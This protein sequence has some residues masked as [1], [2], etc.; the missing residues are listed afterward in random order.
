MF[1]KLHDILGPKLREFFPRRSR[2]RSQNGETTTKPR[3]SAAL[4]FF[5]GGSVLDIMLNHGM[6]K[7]AVYDS[8]Y[9]VVNAVNHT[10]SLD[11][12][13]GGAMFPSYDEQREIA[14]GLL[15]RSGCG[16]D[17]I[18]MALDGMLIWTIMCP[19][20]RT[21]LISTLANASSIVRV[22]SSM[23]ISFWLDATI[24]PGRCQNVFDFSL[25]I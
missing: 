20:R 21:V 23:V 5:A 16:F 3:L 13:E 2:G 14:S 1:N 8:A 17:K 6:S 7:Q 25:C 10:P 24:S 11:F 18:V 12:N 19:L 9:M 22:K 15:R 4:R